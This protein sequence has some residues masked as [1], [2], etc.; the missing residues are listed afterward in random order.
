MCCKISKNYC[1]LDHGINGL[2]SLFC[3]P[4]NR[5]PHSAKRKYLSFVVI[6]IKY[7]QKPRR[8]LKFCSSR[9]LEGDPSRGGKHD[10]NA[11]AC[12]YHIR[13][14]PSYVLRGILFR[15]FMRKYT[16]KWKCLN[17]DLGESA[18]IKKK[19]SSLACS[20]EYFYLSQFT[21]HKQRDSILAHSH[22]Q[23][24][25]GALL[26]AEFRNEMKTKS[27]KSRWS[28]SV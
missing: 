6:K 26:A 9:D 16:A 7:R 21:K 5:T 11:S 24:S 22:K 8:E 15:R 13:T 23:S 12:A 4:T 17:L 20:C 28:S 18:R 10:R 14:I 19:W 1:Y 25:D 27:A 3:V 2:S